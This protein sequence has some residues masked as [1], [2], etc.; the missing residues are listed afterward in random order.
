MFILRSYNKNICLFFKIK[1]LINFNCDFKILIILIF[2]FNFSFTYAQIPSE[3]LKLWYI[4]DSVVL[5]GGFVSEWTDYS[6]NNLH[7]I[8]TTNNNRPIQTN[9]I[10]NIHSAVRFDGTN[11]YL[12]TNFLESLVQPITVFIVWKKNATK[13]QTMFDGFTQDHRISFSYPYGNIELLSIFAGGVG[14]G[15]TYTKPLTNQL[16]VNSIIL[17]SNSKVFDN[18]VLKGSASYVGSNYVDGFIIGA[19]YN[20]TRFLMA[21]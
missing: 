1:E 8:Q 2:L 12:I 11:D 10:Y 20:L 19:H 18:G 9:T 17:S 6:G 16:S 7:A 3:N 4:G 21:I 14:N 15:L 13:P 5:E